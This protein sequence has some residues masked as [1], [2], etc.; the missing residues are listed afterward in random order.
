[1]TYGEASSPVQ[2][3]TGCSQLQNWRKD[4]YVSDYEMVR[5]PINVAL[6]SSPQASCGRPEPRTGRL[7]DPAPPGC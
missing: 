2:R 6:E 1:M 7:D 5:S 4:L 3:D